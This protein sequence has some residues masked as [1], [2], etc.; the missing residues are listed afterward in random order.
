MYNLD[1]VASKVTSYTIKDNHLIDQIGNVSN[2][3]K[4]MSQLGH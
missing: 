4:L 2:S 1:L 3:Q